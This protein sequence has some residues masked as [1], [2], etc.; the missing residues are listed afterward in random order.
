MFGLGSG[1]A[2]VRERAAKVRILVAMISSN[3]YSKT[4]AEFVEFYKATTTVEQ[5]GPDICFGFKFSPSC[6]Y[7]VQACYPEA[8]PVWM[9]ELLGARESADKPQP[10]LSVLGGGD[11]YGVFINVLRPDDGASVELHVTPTRQA[12]KEAKSMVVELLTLPGFSKTVDFI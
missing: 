12:G 11:D 6:W 4:A 1:A 10:S 3:L 2:A 8:E 5:N 9:N 7:D